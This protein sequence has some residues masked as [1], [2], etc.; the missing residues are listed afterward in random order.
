MGAAPILSGGGLY[1]IFRQSGD[2][3]EVGTSSK[4]ECDFSSTGSEG[5]GKSKSHKIWV[6]SHP[7]SYAYSMSDF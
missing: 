7:S 6:G 2:G 4:K 5:L 3:S 1:N